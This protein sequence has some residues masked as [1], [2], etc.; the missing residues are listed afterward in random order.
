MVEKGDRVDGQ[1]INAQSEC[2]MVLIHEEL[3]RS[4]DAET[5]VWGG[6]EQWGKISPQLG[7]WERQ[8]T[9][10]LSDNSR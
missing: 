10:K 8:A 9:P 2:F 1:T 3:G 4:M 7:G 6:G 5:S